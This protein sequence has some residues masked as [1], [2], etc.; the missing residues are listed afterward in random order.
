MLVVA[1]TGSALSCGRTRFSISVQP[2]ITPCAPATANP[3][4]TLLN[5]SR[6]DPCTKS[7]QIY[8][9]AVTEAV[10]EF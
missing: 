8:P 3:S 10:R 5:C 9:K 6:E 2:R 7:S 4:M 1:K